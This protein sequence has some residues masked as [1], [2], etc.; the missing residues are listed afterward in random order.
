MDKIKIGRIVQGFLE[1]TFQTASEFVMKGI[2]VQPQIFLL[3][4]E[5]DHL[6]V[7]QLVGIGALFQSEELYVQ[8][9]PVIKRSWKEISSSKPELELLAVLMLSD[10]W[11]ESVSNAWEGRTDQSLADK[12]GVMEALAIRVSMESESRSFNWPYVRG[13]QG[14][15]FAPNFNILIGNYICDELS[16]NL[17]PL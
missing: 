16:V 1:Q 5:K 8:L 4:D 17:W 15:V 13:K 6:D 12:P 11:M 3:A 9:L 10:T 7:I 2:E 14:A